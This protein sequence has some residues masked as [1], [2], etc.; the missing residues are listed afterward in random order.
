MTNQSIPLKDVLECI[1]RVN[2][3]LDYNVS[4]F[5]TVHLI[6]QEILRKANEI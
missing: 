2:D 5:K 1:E 3:E 4:S 6:R